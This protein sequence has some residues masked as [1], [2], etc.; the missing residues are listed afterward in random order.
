MAETLR[1]QVGGSL[2]AEFPGYVARQ[3]DRELLAH[4]KAGDYCYV[5]NSRQM[6]KSSLRVRTWKRLEAEGIRCAEIN[7]QSRGTSLTEEQWYGGTIKQLISDLHLNDR[8]DL[9]S[10]WRERRELSRT[11]VDGFG[12]FIDQ[13][14]LPAIPGPIV[15]FVEEVDLLLSLEGIDTDGFFGCLRA[16]HER[17]A[18]HPAYQRLSFCLLGVATPYQLI[19]KQRGSGFSVAQPVAMAGFQLE[20]ARPLLAGLQ[21]IEGPP[22]EPAHAESI[23]AA[24]LQ[25][26]CLFYPPDPAADQRGVEYCCSMDREKNKKYIV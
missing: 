20:E 21:P 11:A 10:W 6:G 17:R 13:I 4:L 1:Y 22:L 16:L 14:L 19:R 26:S 3:A 12:D 2:P 8:V 15:I 24:V 9:R 23:P 7:P 25:W 5:F 18:E